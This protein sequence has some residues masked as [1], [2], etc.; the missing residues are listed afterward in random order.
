VP[1]SNYKS[2]ISHVFYVYVNDRI[3][4]ALKPMNDTHIFVPLSVAIKVDMKYK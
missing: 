2:Q 4:K 1:Y 3:E